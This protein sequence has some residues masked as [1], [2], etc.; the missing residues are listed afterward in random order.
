MKKKIFSIAMAV[1]MC[2]SLTVSVAAYDDEADIVVHDDECVHD[3]VEAIIGEVYEPIASNNSQCPPHDWFMQVTTGTATCPNANNRIYCYNTC[4]ITYR[5]W[6]CAKCYAL[7]VPSSSHGGTRHEWY[8]PPYSGI[9][10]CLKC[11]ERW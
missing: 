8:G 11:Y 10:Y 6:V 4:T 1:M 9:G 7:G 3:F 2:F 5:A